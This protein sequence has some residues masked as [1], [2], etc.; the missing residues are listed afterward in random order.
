MPQRNRNDLRS[1]FSICGGA[2]FFLFIA[3]MFLTVRLDAGRDPQ[4]IK[5]LVESGQKNL[6]ISSPQSLTA[7]DMQT[8][9]RAS[10][11]AGG[12]YRVIP[13]PGGITIRG[14]LFSSI[15]RIIPEGKILRVN[16]HS[17]RDSII[18]KNDGA[19]LGA[20]NEIGVES[21]LFGVL[22]REVSPSWGEEALKAQA[23]VSRTYIMR[24]LGRFASKG[25]DLTSCENSQVYGGAECE[26]PATSA[27]V[28]ETAGEVIKYKG[29]IA[30]VFFHAD[31]GGH[32]ESPEF[33]WGS[34]SVPPYLKGRREPVREKTPYSF[35]E[36]KITF[37]RLAEI[38]N[39][40]GYKTGKIKRVII[41]Q[42]TGSGRAKD[43]IIYAETGKT[44]IN[45]GKFRTMLGGRNIK[46]T[47]IK[48]I[49]NERKEV[50]FSGSGWGHGV[51]MS[52]WGAKELAEK[53]WGYKKILEF[54]FP[55]T[56]ISK[57]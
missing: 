25:Y 16:G 33:V 15:V 23:V 49:T 48:K 38:L 13:R 9:R 54:Y 42:K 30:G 3:L 51:G 46:S 1:S 7:V 36:Y 22:P 4:I 43:F 41:S 20:I 31:S 26:T 2:L 57:F 37:D 47:K 19:L 14:E 45:S 28:L 5:V 10:F 8:G 27:A 6:N 35:W 52:Q 55:G 29:N 56:R 21:Y 40:N 32:T 39:K 12:S 18:L 34:S 24:N 44:K 11:P 17:Y 50:V 53:G